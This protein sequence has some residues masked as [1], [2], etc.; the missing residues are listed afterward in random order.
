M[1]PVTRKLLFW[2][3][4]FAPRG[5]AKGPVHLDTPP[6]MPGTPTEDEMGLQTT[7]NRLQ[8]CDFAGQPGLLIILWFLID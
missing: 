6:T 3:G 1:I 8:D 7:R 5:D 4:L 2:G